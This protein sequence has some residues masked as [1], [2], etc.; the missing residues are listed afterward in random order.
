MKSELEGPSSSDNERR[1]SFT[2]YVE[3]G[4]GSANR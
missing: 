1:G 4:E 3:V 2:E